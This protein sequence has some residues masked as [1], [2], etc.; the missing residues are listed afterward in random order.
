[1][2]S[3][4]PTITG[5]ARVGRTLTC[6]AGSQHTTWFQRQ[7]LVDGQARTGATASTFYLGAGD[8][9]R[10]VACRVRAGDASLTVSATSAAP[11]VAL[12]APLTNV[13]RPSI[14]GYSLVGKTLT[15][16]VGSW[17]PTAGSYR[18]QWQVLKG[19]AYVNIYG[20]SARTYAVPKTYAGKYL[21]VRVIAV[22]P[23]HA[24]GSAVS[25]RVRI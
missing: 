17:S 1:V 10:S 7:W 3:P 9:G 25:P 6:S 20:A 23:G 19:G 4:K 8:L 16:R 21:R 24:N 22:K 18:Y 5:T 14:S 13:V 2:I 15:A 12:G 11:K